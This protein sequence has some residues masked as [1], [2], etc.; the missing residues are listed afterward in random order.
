MERIFKGA[1]DDTTCIEWSMCSR[2]LAV[3]S[4]DMCVR[5]YALD[6]YENFRS[7][8]LGGHSQGIVGC[9]FEK[10]SFDITTVSRNGQLCIWV[11]N[12]DPND[13]VPGSAPKKKKFNPDLSDNEEDDVK[14]DRV[15]EKSNSN[16]KKVL[17]M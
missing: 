9:F 7:F 17:P 4:K 12:V 8:L 3:G 14:L 13:L 1:A 2:L 5:I 16:K 11:C 10:N 15:L 6:S